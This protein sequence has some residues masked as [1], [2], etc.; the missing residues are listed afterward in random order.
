MCLPSGDRLIDAAGATCVC[1]ERDWRGADQSD[2]EREKD[3][4]GR[5][6]DEGITD[7]V[8]VHD[9]R[10]PEFPRPAGVLSR[11]RFKQPELF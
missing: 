11:P 2:G 6:M 4:G 1:W 10:E 3:E 8:G 7:P 9:V 5:L